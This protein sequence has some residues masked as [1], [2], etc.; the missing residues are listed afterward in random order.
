LFLNE[1]EAREL[2]GTK[3]LK[4]ALDAL[5]R[6][7]RGIVIKLG[8]RGAIAALD[9][10]RAQ[11]PAPRVRAVDTT[12]AGDSFAGGFVSAFLRGATLLDCLRLGNACGAASTRK[13][14]GTAG[15]PTRAQLVRRL[16]RE[17][18]PC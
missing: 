8:P 6:R 17:G 13:A 12:G 2:S 7:V 3:S 11:A 10:V 4:R 18:T 15:Q 1:R 14:G 16:R 5:A 9:G